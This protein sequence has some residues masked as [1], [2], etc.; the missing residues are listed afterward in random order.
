MT[1]HDKQRV[2]AMEIHR[3]MGGRLQLYRRPG[4]RFWQCAASVGGKQRR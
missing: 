4:S 1:T 2:G 3:L